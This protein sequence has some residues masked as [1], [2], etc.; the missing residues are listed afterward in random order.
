MIICNMSNLLFNFTNFYIIVCL[1]STA[2]NAELVAKPVILGIFLSI[3]V[4]L[5]FKSA[6]LVRSLVSGIFLS[7]SLIFFSTSDLS[8][9]Y[10]VFKTNPA[11]SMLFNLATDLSYTVFLTTSFFTILLILISRYLVYLL[12]FLS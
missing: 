3:S 2:V 12:Q 1:F 11:V 8:V 5:A 10:V 7:A 9:S 4:F 6:F